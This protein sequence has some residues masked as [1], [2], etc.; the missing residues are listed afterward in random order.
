MIIIEKDVFSLI[1]TNYN[2][3]S[4]TQKNIADYIL[5]NPE[6]V[7]LYSISDLASECNT[8]EPTI[9]R[10]LKKIGYE[11]YQ[12]FRIKVAQQISDNSTKSIYGEIQPD[13]DINTVKRKVI[14][15]TTDS[16][17]DLNN[18]VDKQQ[19]NLF[20]DTIIK[21]KEIIFFGV[22]ASNMIAGDAYHKFL[23]LGFNVKFCND[24][25]I[26]NMIASHCHKEDL[27]VAI[28]HSGESREI[29]DAVDFAK[30]NNATIASITSY[31]H[32]ALAKKSDILLLSS[33]RETE[34]RS[35]AMISR[36]NQLVIIDI[37]YVSA[38]LRVGQK[39][40]DSINKSRVAVA[41]N[42]T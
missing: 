11:S 12:V 3:L 37:L 39:C 29:K 19:V 40:I 4:P 8:S 28:S 26:M 31:P 41:K 20:I 23:Q 13:D 32:S 34:Y 5:S 30:E 36:I 14:D 1:R 16:I 6:K 18:I 38:V 27:I 33:S 17:N 9:F 25:H 22:G 21:S 10:F 42:K 15:L 35:D 24:P 7:I 2:N